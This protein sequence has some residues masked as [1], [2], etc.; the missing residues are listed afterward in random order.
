MRRK[1]RKPLAELSY[2]DVNDWLNSCYG[3]KKE[4]TKA[5]SMSALSSFFKF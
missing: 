3:D 5:L 4:K 2:D 1:M